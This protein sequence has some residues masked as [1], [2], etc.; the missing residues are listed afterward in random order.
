MLFHTPRR[1][2]EPPNLTLNNVTVEYV[3][4]FDFLGITVDKSLTW[5][6]HTLKITK[7]ISKTVGIMCRL[8]N[9]LPEQILLKLY[10]SLF[11][12]YIE[13]GLLCWKSKIK[14]LTKL[15]KRAVRIISGKKSISHTEPLFKKLKLLKI[16]DLVYLKL[17]KFCYKL[18]KRNLPFYFL[19][20]L[21]VK[22]NSV[23]TRSLRT[24]D[25]YRIPRLRHEF[26]R[27]SISY[28][29]TNAYNNC[30]EII[31]TKI[32]THSMKGFANYIKHYYLGSYQ[33]LC[34]VRNCRGVE[35]SFS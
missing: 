12:P 22:V 1:K 2:V 30:P 31:R 33:S 6:P 17:Y 4:V 15:Q 24:S 26:A 21:F 34:T 5:K 29:A 8:K 20:N 27:N 32:N 7:K 25:M 14:D 3:D 16:E 10:H 13:Y 18:E 19:D 28:S 35:F 9:F 23:H 11:I